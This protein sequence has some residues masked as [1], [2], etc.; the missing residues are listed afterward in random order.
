MPNSEDSSFF[1][2]ISNFR[3]LYAK[4][5]TTRLES[6]QVRP[7]Y[8][9]ILNRLW[10]RDNI[11]QKQLHAQLAIEQAT[12]SNSLKRMERDG[13]IHRTRDPKDRRLSHIILTEHAK[14]LE[15]LIL[16]AIEELQSVIN[17]GLTINDRRYFNRILKQMASHL[18]SDIDDPCLVLL[19]EIAEE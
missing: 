4:A 19:D 16:A 5:L 3:R 6:Y 7:G 18:E 9:D 15:P 13:L 11:T 2:D 17:V 10:K 8:I 12:L 1:S 14:S